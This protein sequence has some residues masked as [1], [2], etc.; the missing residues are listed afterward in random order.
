MAK[1]DDIQVSIANRAR[2]RHAQ[3][4]TRNSWHGT[5]FLMEA[6]LLL[7]VLVG[8]IAVF[9]QLYAQSNQM[10]V[11]N[12]DLAAAIQLASNEAEQFAADPTSG[13]VS[14]E[15]NEYYVVREVHSE[16]TAAG[17]IYYADI[18]V[19]AFKGEPV[20][21]LSTSTYVSGGDSDGE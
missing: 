5:A 10:S 12:R 7:A 1:N 2:M 9:M 18:T 20:Y 8:C 13:S 6:L 19:T 3:R 21:K 17:T 16:E 14:E 15:E 11:D 4:V